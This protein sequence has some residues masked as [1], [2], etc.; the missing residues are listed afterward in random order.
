[1]VGHIAY[2]NSSTSVKTSKSYHKNSAII[3]NIQMVTKQY[4]EETG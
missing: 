1:M 4:C 3:Y 2:K